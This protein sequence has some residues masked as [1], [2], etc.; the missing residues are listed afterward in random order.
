M[1]IIVWKNFFSMVT[2]RGR[3]CELSVNLGGNAGPGSRPK[4]TEEPGYFSYITRRKQTMTVWDELKARG[5]IAQVT[6][7]EEIK[8]LINNGKATFYIGFDRRKLV[9]W[10]TRQLA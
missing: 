10:V 1:G 8:D 7:E 4:R 3:K 9:H 6:D 2:Y 5:L